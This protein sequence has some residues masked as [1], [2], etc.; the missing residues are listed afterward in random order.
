MCKLQNCCIAGAKYQKPTAI[1][2][3]VTHPH[4]HSMTVAHDPPADGNCFFVSV[5]H[6]LQLHVSPTESHQKLH[7][8]LALFLS[9]LVS[10]LFARPVHLPTH[11]L[12]RS[13][14]VTLLKMVFEQM[15]LDFRPTIWK[16]VRIQKW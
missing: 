15:Q 12:C 10:L 11:L 8:R 5:Q 14:S 4:A 2:R 6:Q 13:F 16:T 1:K 7:Q 3:H 9:D